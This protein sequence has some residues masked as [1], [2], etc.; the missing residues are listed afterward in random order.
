MAL[1][2]GCLAAEGHDRDLPSAEAR[3]LSELKQQVLADGGHVTRNP[4]MVLEILLDLLPIR[5]CYAARGM[6]VPPD[7]AEACE[8]LLHH[9]R[10][11]STG[12]GTLAR[13]NGVGAH[14]V[15]A[16]ATVLA[17]D[18]ARS[19]TTTVAPGPSGYAR[20]QRG[21]TV[22]IVDCGQ[23]PALLHSGRAHAGVLSFELSHAG[24]SV[25]VNSGAA[26][27]AHRRASLDARATASHSTL[28]LDDQSSARL[29][30]LER[31]T[32]AP[33]LA[34]PDSVTASLVEADGCVR[35]V[36]WHNGY[37]GRFGLVHE[38]QLTLEPDGSALVGTD[39][40]RPPHGTL[41]L[42]RDLPLAVH[43]HLPIDAGWRQD[44]VGSIVIETANGRSWCLTVS[45]ARCAI[46]TG[47]D[48]GQSQGP[49]SARQVVARTVTPGETT[50]AW[51]LERL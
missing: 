2:L 15:E 39:I 44:D 23:P 17:V 47:T 28:V 12:P 33:G 20:L 27:P 42:S 29:V 3:L 51:R 49:T 45:G 13:F 11:M 48:Y 38:R 36:A 24:A 8:R 41:R 9:L 26:A 34:G 40:L 6:A 5:Q 18:A 7:L 10:A 16:V 19:A 25:V 21:E 4:E 50:L 32:G 46:E 37:L 43:F 22:V 14:R 30:R 35:L 1:L 31:L